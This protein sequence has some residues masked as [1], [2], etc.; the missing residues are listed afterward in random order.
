MVRDTDH[1]INSGCRLAC[2]ERKRLRECRRRQD[3]YD[4]RYKA[5]QMAAFSLYFFS[6]WDT[7]SPQE[8]TTK[9]QAHD[10]EILAVAF[11]PASE[12]LLV[13]GSAD[14]VRIQ[15]AVVS[16][17]CTYPAGAKDRDSPRH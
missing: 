7:R 15:L 8:A 3:T 9:I 10:Q 1:H 4:V 11:S 6:R 13:T 17:I 16:S 5:S 12:H 2:H 14:K